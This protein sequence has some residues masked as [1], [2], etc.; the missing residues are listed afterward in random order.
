MTKIVTLPAIDAHDN[1]VKREKDA[2]II[3]AH[4]AHEAAGL[5]Y[6]AARTAFQDA[7]DAYNAAINAYNY[8]CELYDTSRALPRIRRTCR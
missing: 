8:A 7:D 3:A 6:I 2:H 4:I 5:A 1:A